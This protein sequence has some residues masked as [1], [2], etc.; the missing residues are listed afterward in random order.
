MKIEYK[1]IGDLKP[2]ARN[3]RKNDDAVDYVANS[4]KEFG[5]IVPVVIDN[6]N[7]IVAGHT[8]YKAAKKLEIEDIPCI[9]ASDLTEKQINAF[10]LA[11]NR[12]SEIATW[13]D[14][15]LK[16]EMKNV[17]DMDLDIYGFDIGTV[18]DIM[19]E[20]TG[21]KTHKCPKCGCEWTQ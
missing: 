6:K 9:I 14:D 20:E 3:P 15:L 19:Q 21:I 10:R 1:K 2:Y 18:E 7:V 16:E 8:R 13:D 5:F 12:V 11:D 17:L 4:I